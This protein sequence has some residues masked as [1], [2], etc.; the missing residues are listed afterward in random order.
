MT[1]IGIRHKLYDYIRTAADKKVKAIYT[2]LE[3]EIEEEYKHWDVKAF[4]IELNKRVI[5]NTN[6]EKFVSFF[7]GKI[8]TKSQQLT[9]INA[10]HNAPLIYIEKKF[11]SLCKG[12]TLLGIQEELREIEVYIFNYASDSTLFCYTDGLADAINASDETLTIEDIKACIVAHNS[13]SPEHINDAILKLAFEHKGELDFTD[14]IALLTLKVTDL[15][16]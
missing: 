16:F 8:N 13:D 2:M 5:N 15:I 7:L 12:T 4:I 3:E 1:T 6:Y 10:G 14:D 9:Y 11:I